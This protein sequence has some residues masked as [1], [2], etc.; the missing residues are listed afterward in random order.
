[1]LALVAAAVL[2]LALPAG[3]EMS[4]ASREPAR[5]QPAPP[6]PLPV[7]LPQSSLLLPSPPLLLAPLLP[8]MLLW[9]LLL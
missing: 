2:A 8:P 9:L 3:G 1:M 4:G 6:L 7:L 5:L